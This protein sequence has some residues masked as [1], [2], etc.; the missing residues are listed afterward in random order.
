MILN[1]RDMAVIINLVE[2]L[3]LVLPIEQPRPQNIDL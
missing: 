1:H 2:N 3:F